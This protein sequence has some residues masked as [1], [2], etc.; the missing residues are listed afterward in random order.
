MLLTRVLVSIQESDEDD[1]SDGLEKPLKS[2]KK[3]DDGDVMVQA[4]DPS[5]FPMR[6]MVIDLPFGGGQLYFNHATSLI[7]IALLWGLA[8]WCMVDP[9][10]SREQLITLRQYC[11][12]YFTWFYIGTRPIFM[13]FILWIA[14]RYGDVRLGPPGSQPEFSNGTYFAM[15]FAAGVAVGLFFYGVSEPLWHQSSHWYANAGY[16]TQDEID[17]F[18][19]NQTIYHWGLSA[20]CGYVV[21]GLACG[22]AAYRFGLPL[23]FRSGLYTILKDYTWGWIGDFIDGI[24]IV[25]TV[26][27]VC[28]SLGLGAMQITAGLIR[29]GW[30]GEELLV[31]SCL[32]N[33]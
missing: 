25:V 3:G 28:T 21:V 8:I 14:F 27:G 4:A 17:M 6:A 16:H 11:A 1:G 33:V 7:G 22:L 13:F 19:I 20:W 18:A 9:E 5:D 23:T 15:L 26:A 29:I 10:G 31:Y 12:L 30:Y 32:Y 2:D 24:T